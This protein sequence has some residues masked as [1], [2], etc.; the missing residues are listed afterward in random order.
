M[1]EILY[2]C[3]RKMSE[4]LTEEPGLIR[5]LQRAGIPLGI[6]DGS[7]G[8]VCRKHG[9][10]PD[11]FML[12]CN[13]YTHENYAPTLS[14]VLETPMAQLVPYLKA[15]H[16]YYV[17]K[18][19]PH[20]EQHLHH[21]ARQLPAKAADV[22]MR[23]FESYKREVTDHF[24]H[25]EQLVFPHVEALQRGE[26][27]TNYSIATFIDSH[28]NLEDK[29]NDLVQIIFKYLPGAVTSEDS[30]DVVYDIL[31][32]SSDLNKHSL[33]EEKVLVPYVKH[34]EEVVSR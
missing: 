17:S 19:L 29:L 32:V 14:R 6:G 27:D 10:N 4:L 23:F 8:Q 3:S 26:A 18:R 9:V 13:I 12:L 34:L 7:I 28:G 16:D 33:I 11:F 5:I 22:F 30:V 24:A 2:D 1:K 31:Q 20:I 25:E 21:I 15:S